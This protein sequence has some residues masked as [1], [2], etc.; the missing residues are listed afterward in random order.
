MKMLNALIVVATIAAVA[1]P[2]LG[3]SRAAGAGDGVLL[4]IDHCGGTTLAY[5]GRAVTLA[6]IDMT[7]TPR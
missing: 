3:S 7:T 4:P 2:V 1:V 6:C 5:D